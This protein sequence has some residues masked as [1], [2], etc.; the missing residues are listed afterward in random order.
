MEAKTANAAFQEAE[1]ILNQG[2]VS[3][4][5]LYN[6]TAKTLL[7]T[8]GACQTTLLV[9]GAILSGGSTGPAA[10]LAAA[11]TAAQG[12]DLAIELLNIGH[13]LATDESNPTLD[14]IKRY[15][16]AIA[17]VTNLTSMVTSLKDFALRG[18]EAVE[19]THKA[20]KEAGLKNIHGWLDK[21][22]YGG[23]G[24]SA[25]I[26][27]ASWTK[28]RYDD[29]K[30]D[31]IILG[32]KVF[33]VNGKT[34]LR[35]TALPKADYAPP[36]ELSLISNDDLIQLTKQPEDLKK[37]LAF[38][39]QQQ[40][41]KKRI[42]E[43]IE[44][45]ARR[46]QEIAEDEARREAEERSR[47]ASGAE[48]PQRSNKPYTGAPFSGLDLTGRFRKPSSGKTEQPKPTPENPYTPTRM[49]GYYTVTTAKGDMAMRVILRATGG[50][51]LSVIEV[52]KKTDQKGKER[53]AV[54]IDPKSG[55]GKTA[56]GQPVRFEVMR[57]GVTFMGTLEDGSRIWRFVKH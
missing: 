57:D 21:H 15:T 30:N 42:W 29:Y 40:D 18:E 55:K 45:D 44:E 41:A 12:A 47:N 35:P 14:N 23:S 34:A 19:I 53:F 28:D 52:Q 13:E 24:V 46:R 36:K 25:I 33:D 10:Y 48:S 20:L 16:G 32:F 3:E 38:V 49:A 22:G 56:Q 4:A 27:W 2:N 5:Q 6:I 51:T 17:A 37:L 9:G 39:D 11:N 7:V 8:K 1:K 54:T 26:D 31:G 50:N 43:I